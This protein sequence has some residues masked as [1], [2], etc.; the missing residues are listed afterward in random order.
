MYLKICVFSFVQFENITSYSEWPYF[1][2][3]ALAGLGAFI[4]IFYPI[5]VGYKGRGG[6]ENKDKF[7]SKYHREYRGKYGDLY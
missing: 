3:Y 7:T 6:K 2:S 5:Y 1:T 4:S